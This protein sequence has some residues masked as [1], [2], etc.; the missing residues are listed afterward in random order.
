MAAGFYFGA[1]PLQPIVEGAR[2]YQQLHGIG[3]INRTQF[4]DVVSP[5]AATQRIATAYDRLPDFDPGAVPAFRAMRE[6]TMR[7]YDH[8]TKPRSRGGMGIDINVTKHDPYGS[9]PRGVH[10]IVDEIRDDVLNHNRINVFSTATT[11]GHPFFSDDDNDAFRG[12]HDLFGHL[13]SGRGIDRHGEE[14]AFQKHAQMYT[15]LAR[16]AMATETRGQNAALHAHGEFQEQKIALLPSSMRRLDF[17]RSAA[18]A[19]DRR[20]A[21][22]ENRKQG[23]L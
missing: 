18:T 7:Q 16:A 23:L 17:L 22:D 20:E 1:R 10:G 5:M 11:G 8:I 13:G 2:N 14:A 12:V 6:E 3:N 19:Q 9:G 4:G 15:P 21:V